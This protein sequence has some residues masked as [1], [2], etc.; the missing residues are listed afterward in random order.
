MSAEE[1][2][3]TRAQV[4]GE[5]PATHWKLT[6][7]SDRRKRIEKADTAMDHPTLRS[8]ALNTSHCLHLRHKG[9]Y[10]T[11]A[12]DPDEWSFYDRYDATAYWC[13]CTQKPLGPDG[14]PVGPDRCQP[15][16]SCCAH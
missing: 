5:E 10:V 14:A 4:A 7:P 8:H 6:P 16:R 11:S 12:P 1:P 15:G 13:T 9:M 3:A 2:K